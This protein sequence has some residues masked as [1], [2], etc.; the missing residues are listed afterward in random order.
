MALSHTLQ[1]NVCQAWN[2]CFIFRK[3]QTALKRARVHPLA[4]LLAQKIYGGQW[5]SGAVE[6]RGSRLGK[7]IRLETPLLRVPSPKGS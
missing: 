5:S 2:C 6:N 4:I 7:S 1:C 3:D